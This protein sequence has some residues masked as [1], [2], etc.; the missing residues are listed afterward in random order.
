[1]WVT[2]STQYPKISMTKRPET[3][4]LLTLQEDDCAFSQQ[5]HSVE[6]NQ[7]KWFDV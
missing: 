7:H 5:L 6:A 1:M 3:S 4:K 2:V